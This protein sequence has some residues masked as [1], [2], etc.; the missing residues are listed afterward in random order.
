MEWR[1]RDGVR[2]LEAELG[3]AR[4]AFTTRRGGVSDAPF[5]SLNLGLLTDDDPGSVSMNRGRLATALGRDPDG[6]VFAR[7]VH[8]AKLIEHRGPLGDPGEADGHVVSAAELT[9]LVFV[10]DCLPV[11]LSG[12]GGVAMLHC[13]WRGLAAE[14]VARGA[15][16]VAAADAAVGPGIGPCCYEVGPEVLDAFDH[17]DEGIARD[18][19]LDL[20]EVAVRSLREAGVERVESIALC[21]SCNPDLFFSHRRDAGRTGRQAGLAWIEEG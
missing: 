15:E 1:E 18:R 11:A 6:V 8:G 4:A 12:P 17:L 2:W 3:G 5:D 7:Q 13:G 14:I 21:T 10:A 16:A 20:R 9:P 19:M